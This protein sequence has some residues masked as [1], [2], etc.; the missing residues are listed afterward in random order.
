M[1][2]DPTKAKKKWLVWSPLARAELHAHSHC[3]S[4]DTNLKSILFPRREGARHPINSLVQSVTSRG[5]SRLDEPLTTTQAPQTKLISDLSCW[6][7]VWQ[8]LLVSKHQDN[9]I[10]HFILFE[11]LLQFFSGIFNPLSVIAVH[12]INQTIGA[13][14]VVTPQT[15]DFILTSH[16]P[17]CEA[18]VLVLDSFHI[19]PDCGDCRHHL[20]QLELVKNGCLARCVQANHED[21]HV[22]FPCKAVPKS[23]EDQTHLDRKK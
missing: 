9:C 2:P 6:H 7:C 4:P 21:A 14:V 11:H 5:T 20:T 15:A 22:C 23:G 13:L 8:I 1:Q 19:E 16:V 10:S 12:H 3:S 18:D 17:H